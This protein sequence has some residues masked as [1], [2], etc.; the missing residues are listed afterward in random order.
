[1]SLFCYPVSLTDSLGVDDG[2]N[3]SGDGGMV[4]GIYCRHCRHDSW[5]RCRLFHRESEMRHW[6]MKQRWDW[7]WYFR[8]DITGRMVEADKYMA[9]GFIVYCMVMVMIVG[10]TG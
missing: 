1:M 4:C 5:G 8:R 3:G 2:D 7:R 9:I 10:F 6:K